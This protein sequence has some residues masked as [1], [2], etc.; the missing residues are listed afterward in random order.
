MQTR[1]RQLDRLHHIALSIQPPLSLVYEDT[2][3]NHPITHNLTLLFSTPSSLQR[4][5]DTQGMPLL[6]RTLATVSC[7]FAQPI[8]RRCVTSESAVKA[9]GRYWLGAA[10]A[11]TWIPTSTSA[12]S[13]LRRCCDGC[14]RGFHASRELARSSFEG[15]NHYE[16]LKVSPDASP[17]EIKKYG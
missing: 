7:L 3:I 14:R 4:D 9:Y 15:K 13:R 10:P 11:S 8:S 12:G 16:R 5:E 2:G 1:Q 6:P 17:A